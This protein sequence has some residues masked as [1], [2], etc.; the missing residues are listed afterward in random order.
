MNTCDRGRNCKICVFF[1]LWPFT[2]PIQKSF[3]FNF[4][5]RAFL[6]HL[7]NVQAYLKSL[8]HEDRKLFFSFLFIR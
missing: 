4:I 3:I 5:L 8:R 6:F 7:D 1:F 2:L